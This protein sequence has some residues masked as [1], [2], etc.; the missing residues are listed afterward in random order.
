MIHVIRLGTAPTLERGADPR[1]PDYSQSSAVECRAF[2]RML[3]RR[4]LPPPD[5][6]AVFPILCF[7]REGGLVSAPTPEKGREARHQIGSS[8]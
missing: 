4:W 1:S 3:E 7:A 2:R 8:V 5:H 6:S